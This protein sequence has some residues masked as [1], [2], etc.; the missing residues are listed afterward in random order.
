[1][2]SVSSMHDSLESSEVVAALSRRCNTETIEAIFNN[3]AIANC[4][5]SAHFATSFP[6]SAQVASF[7]FYAAEHSDC[8]RHV[9]DAAQWGCADLGI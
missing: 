5:S 2:M 8:F 6:T 3:D 4:F 9:F 7:T 1:M